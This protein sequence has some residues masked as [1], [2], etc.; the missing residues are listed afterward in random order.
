M[1]ST[2]ARQNHCHTKICKKRNRPHI[3]CRFG[4]PFMPMERTRILRTIEPDEFSADEIRR[5]KVLYLRIRRHF[6]GFNA[7]T[8]PDMT[9]DQ[10]WKLTTPTLTITSL[11]LEHL[12]IRR[13]SIFDE[14]FATFW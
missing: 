6:E 4:I 7:N 9:F 13:K 2:L 3:K 1:V 14:G 5:F 8:A 10:F 11:P 12:R